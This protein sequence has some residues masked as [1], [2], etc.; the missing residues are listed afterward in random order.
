MWAPPG[1]FLSADSQFWGGGGWR[2]FA[3]KFEFKVLNETFTRLFTAVV[4][5]PFL[6]RVPPDVIYFQLCTPKAVGFKLY[7]AYNILN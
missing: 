3:Y 1:S 7:K 6:V 4:F 2:E 5:N